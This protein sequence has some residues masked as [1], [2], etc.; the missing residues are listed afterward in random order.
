MLAVLVYCL[1]FLII[2]IGAYLFNIAAYNESA[3]FFI[4][5]AFVTYL[6][7]KP[8]KLEKIAKWI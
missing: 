5:G 6:S 2:V 8:E 3:F 1:Y 4:G 7:N